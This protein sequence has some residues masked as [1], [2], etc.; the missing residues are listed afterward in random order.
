MEVKTSIIIAAL[1]DETDLY[2][3]STEDITLRFM[4]TTSLAD[5]FKAKLPTEVEYILVLLSVRSTY[6]KVSVRTDLILE[7]RR[8]IRK[9][10]DETAN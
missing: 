1:F 8:G 4:P 9:G 7:S 3:S 10:F 6:F 2:Y 5:F